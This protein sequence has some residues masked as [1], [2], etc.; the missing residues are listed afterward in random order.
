VIKLKW[1]GYNELPASTQ[2]IAF[3]PLLLLFT[4]SYL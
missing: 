4:R 2:V 3:K 1:F